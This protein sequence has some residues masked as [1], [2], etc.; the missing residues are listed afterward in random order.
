MLIDRGRS[1]HK[2]IIDDHACS[3]R[4]HTKRIR[5]LESKRHIAVRILF[6]SE[7][8]AN[9][10]TGV[11]GELA[12]AVTEVNYPDGTLWAYMGDNPDT[13]GLDGPGWYQ[14][15]TDPAASD[16]WVGEDCCLYW[17]CPGGETMMFGGTPT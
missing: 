16:I 9:T 10:P 5:K 2:N 6:R 12:L 8:E 14:V 3:I 7:L 11:D 13:V 17:R 4:E 1:G 15:G